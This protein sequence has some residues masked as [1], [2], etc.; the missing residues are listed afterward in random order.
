MTIVWTWLLMQ[1]NSAT[2][3]I[4]NSWNAVQKINAR[5]QFALQSNFFL[6]RL[7]ITGVNCAR[8]K[9]GGGQTANKF[10]WWE[11]NSKS[12]H[13]YKYKD[14]VQL[15][16]VGVFQN[17]PKTL[18]RPFEERKNKNDFGPWSKT[19]SVSAS[20]ASTAAFWRHWL[21]LPGFNGLHFVS[22]KGKWKP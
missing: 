2:K 10:L 1:W 12:I 9:F 8:L 16:T 13:N 11:V 6:L 4:R 18:L 19:F 20:N 7:K 14:W 17:W 21:D 15:Q 3:L 5:V 22:Q